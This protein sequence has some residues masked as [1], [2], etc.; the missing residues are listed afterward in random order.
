M[1]SLQQSIAPLS[2]QEWISS[3]LPH[4][5]ASIRSLLLLHISLQPPHF[6]LAAWT[7]ADSIP[8]TILAEASSLSLDLLPPFLYEQSPSTCCFLL[9]S[10]LHSLPSSLFHVEE[11]PFSIAPE[12]VSI[13]ESHQMSF[14]PRDAE[15]VS[16]HSFSHAQSVLL[17][18]TLFPLFLGSF[19]KETISVIDA[20]ALLLYEA[21]WKHLCFNYSLRSPRSSPSSC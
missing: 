6:P 15:G 7:L 3:L 13:L 1:T 4:A 14:P 18:A 9:H 16:L 17:L 8:S 10:A 11:T 19:K 5:A 2:L 21:V 20:N 12:I